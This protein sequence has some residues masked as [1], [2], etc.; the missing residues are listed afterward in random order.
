MTIKEFFSFKSNRF[1]WL[2]I[3]GMIAFVVVALV[4]TFQW[5]DSYTRHGHSVEVPDLY[6]MS[7]NEAAEVLRARGLEF[8]VTDSSYIKGM[9]AYRVLQ[10]TPAAGN[11]V[12]ERRIIYLTISSNKVPLIKVPDIIDNSS[13][14][15][16]EARLRAAGFKLGETE[17]V[18][19][20]ARDWVVGVKFNGTELKRNSSI[21]E[22]ATL[23]IV[24]GMGE[25][26][27]TFESDT[28]D[29]NIEDAASELDDDSWFR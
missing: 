3:I 24:A 29:T 27:T 6:G 20:A 11:K 8:T 4:V 25:G 2:N 16:A 15:E 22:G 7:L 26:A 13:L 9:P 19:N 14:R 12:K 5:L 28:L 18:A 1:F 21:P 23:V 17:F 10:N